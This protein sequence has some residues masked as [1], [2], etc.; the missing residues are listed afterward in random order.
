MP[1]VR[2]VENNIRWLD[3]VAD[4]IGGPSLAMIP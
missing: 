4:I 2:A 3:L 1:A